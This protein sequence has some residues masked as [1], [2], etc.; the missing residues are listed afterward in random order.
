MSASV[1]V[2]AGGTGGAKLARGML[3]VVG[4]DSLTVIANTGDDI[5]IYGAYVS[6][7]PDLVTFWLADRI[8]ERGWGLAGDTF[9]VMDGLKR[10]SVDVWFNLGD[11]DLAIGIERARRLDRGER[12][13]EAQAAIA[14]ALQAPGRVLPMSD[15]PVRTHVMAQDRWWPFQEYMIRSRGEGPVQDVDFRGANNAQPTPEIRDALAA[16]DAIVIGPSNPIISVAPILAVPGIREALTDS[17]A[18]VVAVSPFVGGR[19]I[20]GPTEAFME[21]AGRPL[22]SDGLAAHYEDLIDG[23]VAD[24]RATAL[25]TLETDVLMDTENARGR[26]A[27]DTLRFALALG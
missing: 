9:N 2:L 25:P 22:T 5:E 6:P 3:D 1:V 18:P 12:L 15:I 21:W 27:E 16:A 17:K 14:S 11:E 8:D 26:V 23:V 13:T 24:H 7:D 10:L 20:K 19:V 4:G